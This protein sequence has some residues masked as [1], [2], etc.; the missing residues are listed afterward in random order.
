MYKLSTC[1]LLYSKLSNEEPT[2]PAR[3]NKKAKEEEPPI[4]THCVTLH[5]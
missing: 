5:P 3:I 2:L 1:F 4:W